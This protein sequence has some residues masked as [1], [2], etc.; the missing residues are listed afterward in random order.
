MPTSP[1]PSPPLSAARR[2]W[3]G[4][5]V[6]ASA[7]AMLAL[8]VMVN[9]LA[10][11]HLHQRFHW[12]A[13][14][15]WQ[16]TPL[17]VRLLQSVTNDVR[18]VVF[19]HRDN[20]PSLYD[21]I[22]GLLKEYSLA[23]TKIRVDYIDYVNHPAAAEVFKQQYK[24][25][26]KTEHDLV[27]FDANGKTREV[28]DTELSD[29]DLSGVLSGRTR[30]VR[31]TTFKGELLFTSAIAGVTDP[32]RPKA[33]FL[34]GHGEFDPGSDQEQTGYSKMA[35]VLREKDIE[36]NRLDL[37]GTNDVPSDSLLV[38]AGATHRLE[39]AEV[40]RVETFLERGGRLLL[41][42]RQGYV[43]GLEPTLATNW[44]VAVN[45]RA[46]VYERNNAADGYILTTNFGDHPIVSPLTDVGLAL[47]LPLPVGKL[48]VARPEADAPAVKEII[49]SS[50][51]GMAS[52][53]DLSKG[54]RL[55]PRPTDPQGAIPMAVAVEKG[56]IQGVRAD[57]GAARLVVVG[58]S[59]FLANQWI[60]A[61]ANRDFAALAA[62]W[63][64]DRRQL[65]GGIGPRPI[66]QYRI[67]LT[68]TQLRRVRWILLA[69]LPGGVLVLGLLVWWVRRH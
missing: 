52:E 7:L 20:A 28:Y 67:L 24:R 48:P 68:D 42:L 10:E 19:F 6:A 35:A 37:S 46:L 33:C 39:P 26:F 41:L 60:E 51:N 53:L 57:R 45:E 29:Y 61:K 55:Q 13:N 66:T 2:W 47:I 21:A 34:D 40:R 3:I 11:R 12:T 65:L 44:D 38:I 1:T 23:N 4:F 64:L 8:V 5:N 58:E 9:Y 32:T 59:L 43:T 14:R 56:G 18:V 54:L 63:L 16:L 69:G 27:L 30:E 49:F 17:T 25:P 36:V 15:Q 62:D 50:T 22:A 31:R